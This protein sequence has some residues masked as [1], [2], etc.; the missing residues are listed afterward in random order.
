MFVFKNID[1]SGTTTNKS[2]VHYTQNLNT[3]SSGLTSTQFISAS[4]NDKHWQS[5]NVLFYT[6]GSPT[7]S[8]E[9][10]FNH[11]TSNFT[12]YNSKHPQHLNK[13]HGYNSGSIISI[14]QDHYSEK[15]KTGTFILTDKSYTNNAGNNPIIKDDGYGNLYSTNATISQSADTSISSSDNYVGNIFYYQGIA[16]LTETGSWSG[17]VNYTD[18][19]SASNYTVQFDS[20]DTIYTKEYSVTINPNEFDYSMNY[21]LRCLPSGSSVTFVRK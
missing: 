14:T 5:L 10:K 20:T 2:I 21:S 16:I 17:S 3:G 18:I 4:F 9:F 15:I 12:I 1:K 6:S 7:F 8:S 13:F 11:H 19:T